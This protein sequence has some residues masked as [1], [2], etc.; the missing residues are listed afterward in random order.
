MA[1]VLQNPK[2]GLR[3]HVYWDVDELNDY[4]EMGTEDTRNPDEPPEPE[5]SVM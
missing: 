2:V 5:C 1:R 3:D 4:G